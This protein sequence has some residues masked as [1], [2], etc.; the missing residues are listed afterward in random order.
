M[1]QYK[2]QQQ[3]KFPIEIKIR[4]G[5]HPPTHLGVFLGFFDFF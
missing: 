3:K 5:L 4:V 1:K 2:K